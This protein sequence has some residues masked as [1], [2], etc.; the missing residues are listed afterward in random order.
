[1][2][3]DN[4]GSKLI[5]NYFGDG[6]TSALIDQETHSSDSSKLLRS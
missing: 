1:M 6:L 4:T 5:G 2:A 3:Y